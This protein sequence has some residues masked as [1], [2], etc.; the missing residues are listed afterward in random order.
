M[1]T[2]TKILMT[3]TAILGLFRVVMAVNN[4]NDWKSW[5]DNVSGR[6]MKIQDE[7]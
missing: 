4:D 5:Y 1:K 3:M 6:L 2:K 7:D